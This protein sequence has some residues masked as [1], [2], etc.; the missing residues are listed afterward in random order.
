MC[1]LPH[2]V[3]KRQRKA[4][5]SYLSPPGSSSV[6]RPLCGRWCWQDLTVPQVTAPPPRAMWHKVQS[7]CK[8]VTH[9]SSCIWSIGNICRSFFLDRW[10]M[11]FSSSRREW[12]SVVQGTSTST[13]PQVLQGTVLGL[14]TGSSTLGPCP[15]RFHS[16]PPLPILPLQSNWQ[17]FSF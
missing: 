7:F 15:E 6:R 10:K 2:G 13:Y 1:V 17:S 11:L 4:T 3:C 8:S 5:L 9:A 16:V 14:L 12:R